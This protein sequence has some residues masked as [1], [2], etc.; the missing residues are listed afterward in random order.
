[1]TRQT[2][3]RPIEI[4]LVEDDLGDVRLTEVCFRDAKVRNRLTVVHDGVDAL[5]YLRRKGEYADAV[6]PDL[7]LLDLN[8]PRK[9]GQE[10][11]REMKEDSA[12]RS[13]PVVVL[14]SSEAETDILQSY[15]LHAN[16]YIT[17]PVDLPQFMEVVA[18]VE[19]FWLCVVKLPSCIAIPEHV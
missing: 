12:L 5:A 18:A 13:I 8:M 3:G 14:T 4:L 15:D 9:N 16:C 17:K 1:M 7:V 6:R 19:D 10:V 2:L 11:L